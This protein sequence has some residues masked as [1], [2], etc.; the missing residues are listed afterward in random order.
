MPEQVKNFLSF[1]DI[2]LGLAVLSALIVGFSAYSSIKTDITEL[3]V[4]V[5][6]DEKADEEVLS[7]LKKMNESTNKL[8]VTVAKIEQR[9]ENLER[10]LP[11]FKK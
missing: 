5:A 9:F 6:L 11:D 8:N 1:E 3:Q 2:K 4:K 10:V 7:Y